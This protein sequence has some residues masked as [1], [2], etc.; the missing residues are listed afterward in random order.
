[1]QVKRFNEE[2][3]FSVADIVKISCQDMEF[4]KESSRGNKRKRARLCT[5]SSIE[6]RLHEMFIVHPKD[7]YVRPHKHLGK[8]ESVHI[9]EGSVDVV[10]FDEAGTIAESFR[11]GNYSSGCQFYYRI[12]ADRYHSLLIRSEW[13]IFHEITTGPFSKSDTVF[14]PWAPEE[15]ADVAVRDFMQRTAQSLEMLPVSPALPGCLES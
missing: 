7:A 11:L 14:A 12:P 15:S 9:I 10:L 13:L 2:V 3:Y 6:D 1:M 8:A 5:H 4:L